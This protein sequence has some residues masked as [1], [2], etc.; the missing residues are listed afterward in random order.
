MCERIERNRSDHEG[1][2]LRG[3]LSKKLCCTNKTEEKPIDEGR[4]TPM[5]LFPRSG[6]MW[7][8]C[9]IAHPL[10]VPRVVV[11]GLLW[12][13]ITEMRDRSLRAR[14]GRKGRRGKRTKKIGR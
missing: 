13:L 5:D 4:K 9:S 6:K 8:F 12:L 3:N 1:K 14:G 7:L 10:F 11:D 2:R